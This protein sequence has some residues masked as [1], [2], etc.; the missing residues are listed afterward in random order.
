[1]HVKKNENIDNLLLCGKASKKQKSCHIIRESDGYLI[2]LAI[3]S[4]P[5]L[6]ENERIRCLKGTSKRDPLSL[7]R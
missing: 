2:G 7:N 5:K 4:H 1:M 6:L 3:R